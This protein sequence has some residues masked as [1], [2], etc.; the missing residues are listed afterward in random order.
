MSKKGENYID[1]CS[2]E[3]Y[4][5]NC[6]ECGYCKTRDLIKCYCCGKFNENDDEFDNLELDKGN[7]ALEPYRTNCGECDYCKSQYEK[8]I[9][10]IKYFIN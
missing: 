3:P 5:T 2:L 7:C 6:G 4:R 9:N 8:L 10:S 1:G